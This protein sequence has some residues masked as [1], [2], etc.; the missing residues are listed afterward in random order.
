M[1]PGDY[2]DIIDHMHHRSKTRP[3]MSMTERAAQFAPFAALVGYDDEVREAER[4]TERR[5]ILDED[6]LITLNEK[7]VQIEDK[8]KEQPEV[9]IRY[10]KQDAFKEGGAYEEITERVKKIDRFE[11]VLLLIDQTKI[12]FSDIQSIDLTGQ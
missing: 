7:L 2:S 5:I 3:A 10:F 1:S 8:E 9:W 12:A 6:L 11:Q 4:Q